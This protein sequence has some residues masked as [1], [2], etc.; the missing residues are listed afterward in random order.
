MAAGLKT[1][2][3]KFNMA[4]K[5]IVEAK[6]RL[7]EIEQLDEFD[8]YVGQNLDIFCDVMG[9]LDEISSNL[10]RLCNDIPVISG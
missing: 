6:N 4:R 1:F 2:R 7:E 9:G 3:I 8:I 10:Y 5:A